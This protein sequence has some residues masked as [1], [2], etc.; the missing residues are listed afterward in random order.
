MPA[1]RLNS[2][3]HGLVCPDL[4]ELFAH[5]LARITRAVGSGK[6]CGKIAVQELQS[7]ARAGKRKIPKAA[8]R[9]MLRFPSWR[10][11]RGSNSPYRHALPHSR[12]RLEF[13][14]RNLEHW[15]AM[16]WAAENVPDPMVDGGRTSV[17]QILGIE[18]GRAP[19]P[20]D[21]QVVAS[22]FQWLGTQSGQAF[23]REKI[24]TALDQRLPG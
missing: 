19:T 1:R 17:H 21:V 3:V 12:K 20:H 11:M 23:L 5:Q 24:L 15:M 16:V 10:S 6:I 18:D 2:N 4:V 9:K 14:Y 7:I 22:V 13:P 8:S